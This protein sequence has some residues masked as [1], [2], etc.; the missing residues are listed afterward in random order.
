LTPVQE[1]RK[2]PRGRFKARR[3]YQQPNRRSE[4]VKNS[5]SQ[6]TER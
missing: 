1:G 3:G 4:S 6:K 5:G 2:V